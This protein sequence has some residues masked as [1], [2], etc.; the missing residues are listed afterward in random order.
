MRLIILAF[1]FI[2][3]SVAS[4]DTLA[5]ENCAFEQSKNMVK[6][7]FETVGLKKPKQVQALLDMTLKLCRG[8]IPANE[9]K[10]DVTTNAIK[11]GVTRAVRE[12]MGEG[13]EIRNPDLK[14]SSEIARSNLLTT[15]KKYFHDDSIF[16]EN[17]QNLNILYKRGVI[18]DDILLSNGYI[19]SVKSKVSSSEE[20]ED[21]GLCSVEFTCKHVSSGK[22]KIV[23]SQVEKAC[24]DFGF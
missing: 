13:L 16:I 24:K 5:I 20:T 11:E 10:I 3:E 7:L 14:T 2:F 6:I 17:L 8:V 18:E 1:I 19:C 21:D 15:L 12:V 9:E 23:Y 22:F 4:A